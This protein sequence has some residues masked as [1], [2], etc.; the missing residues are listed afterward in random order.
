MTA[1]KI[2]DGLLL[3]GF[4][5]SFDRAALATHG[6]THVLNVAD[7]CEVSCRV[8][9]TYAKVGAI[10]DDCEDDDMSAILPDCLAFVD[11]CM[12]GRGCV[13]VHCLEGKSR[14]VCVV[15][16]Y[17]VRRCGVA[18]DDAL[19]RVLRARPCVD[20]FPLFLEQTRK[21]CERISEH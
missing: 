21:W 6:V 18:W 20:V 8:D 3:A 14:S 5:E 7:E 11:G 19:G 12:H 2:A 4:E 17:L 1:T 15:L 13:L 10:R 16:A 9:L